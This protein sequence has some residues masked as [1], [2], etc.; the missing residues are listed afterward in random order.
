MKNKDILELYKNWD[1][2]TLPPDELMELVSQNPFS[3]LD[4]QIVNYKH[5]LIKYQLS[6][7][8]IKNQFY[9][10]A[11]MLVVKQLSLMLLLHH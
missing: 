10:W 11:L 9:L 4:V 1:G 5:F 3:L 8:T 6:L 2:E 7:R